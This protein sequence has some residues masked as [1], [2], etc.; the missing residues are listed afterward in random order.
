MVALAAC[1]VLVGVAAA[2]SPDAG[3]TWDSSRPFDIDVGYN[4]VEGSISS[5]DEYDYWE[6]YDPDV[7]DNLDLLL[8][9]E[10]YNNNVIGRIYDGDHDKIGQVSKLFG[11]QNIDDTL[12]TSN[13]FV[14]LRYDDINSDYAF[15][16]YRS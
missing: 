13:A 14:S 12:D 16:V 1:V 15:G 4:W 9:S 6:S 10:A 3:N 7:G 11:N 8:N 5:S 2:E